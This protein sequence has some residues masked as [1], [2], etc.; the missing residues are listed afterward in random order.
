MGPRLSS[1]GGDLAIKKRKVR[2]PFSKSKSLHVVFKSES[3]RGARSMLG[4][5]FKLR[6]EEII[7][8]RAKA[9]AIRLQKHQN[10]GSH[11]HVVL[12]APNREALR[13]FL[14]TV[15]G[16]I[17]R[18]VTGAQKGRPAK[19]KFWEKIAF[20]RV[21]QGLRDFRAMMNYLEKNRVEAEQ[22]RRARRRIEEREKA[23]RIRNSCS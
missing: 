3:A 4:P 13:N 11:I 10:V 15:A 21:V 22:G 9:A 5:K 16:L 23:D 1:H 20:S 14:R 8:R 7:L 6:I 2:R 17:A 18:L 12:K 19:A